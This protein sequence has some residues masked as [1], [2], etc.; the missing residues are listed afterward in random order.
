[1]G[2]GYGGA[3][4]T[5]PTVTEPEITVGCDGEPLPPLGAG[6]LQDGCGESCDDKLLCVVVVAD[7]VTCESLLCH[8]HLLAGTCV[9][10]TY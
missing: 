5:M 8:S 6:K 3:G 7:I 10:V 2:S 1:M 9:V 4:C